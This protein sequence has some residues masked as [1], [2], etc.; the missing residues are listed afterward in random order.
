MKIYNHLFLLFIVFSLHS[1]EREDQIIAHVEQCIA[2]AE[3]GTSKLTPQVLSIDG[4]S[5]PKVR[6]FLNHLCSMPDT[7]YLEIGC[8]KGS[9]WIAA[10]YKNQGTISSATAIDDWSEFGGP[11]NAF[12]K[13]CAM[14]LT[15]VPCRYI[16]KDCFKVDLSRFEKPINVYFYDGEHSADSQEKAFTYFDPV[17]DDL[18]IAVIDDW[19]WPN[20][21]NG[22]RTAFGKLNYEIL[23]ET[24]LPSYRTNDAKNWW[25]GL[26]VAVIRKAH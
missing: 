1:D 26:Y 21:S 7:R 18:F 4:M 24:A 2:D 9:T 20:V 11:K 8:F 12:E 15:N 13:N 14:F 6:H 10:L 3:N 25:N 17:L 19:N 16:S 22:T 5:S 23:F